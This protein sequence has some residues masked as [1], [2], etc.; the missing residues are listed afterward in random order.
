[1]GLAGDLIGARTSGIK[2]GGVDFS[3]QTR[4]RAFRALLAEHGADY[5]DDEAVVRAA[6]MP[7]PDLPK[8]ALSFVALLLRLPDFLRLTQDHVESTF[9]DDAR[10]R[11]KQALGDRAVIRDDE[12]LNAGLQEAVP[13]MVLEANDRPPVAVI[14]AQSAQRI[15]DAVALQMAALYEA[16]QPL[17]VIALLEKEPTI[18]RELRQRAAN[19]LAAVPVYTGDESAAIQR[20]VIG[21]QIAVH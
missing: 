1:M 18:S 4:Q 11:V 16:K 12:P 6:A 13:D 9:R 19:R 10:K 5:D 8:A 14:F 21:P 15:D 2:M 3:T 20:E 17:S 7:E